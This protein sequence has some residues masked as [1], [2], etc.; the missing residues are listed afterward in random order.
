ME[1]LRDDRER[2]SY[3]RQ[4]RE[5]KDEA[6]GW[7]Q[8]KKTNKESDKNSDQVLELLKKITEGIIYFLISFNQNNW[9]QAKLGCKD[10]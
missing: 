5:A 2:A 6:E 10:P 8:D 7:L 3:E 1:D 4:K 9:K